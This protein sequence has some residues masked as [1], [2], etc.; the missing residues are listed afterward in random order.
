MAMSI[1]L[2]RDKC[3]NKTTDLEGKSSYYNYRFIGKET[4]KITL[5]T[6]ISISLENLEVSKF[7]LLNYLKIQP[8]I[9]KKSIKL[10][11]MKL[12]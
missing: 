12:Y 1:E 3:V 8:L 6:S 4:L 5:A 7:L 11:N 10:F 9:D 2:K